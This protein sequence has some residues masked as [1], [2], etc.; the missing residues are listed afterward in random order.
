MS[1]AQ[2][3]RKRTSPFF[4]GIY[5]SQG[6][7][8]TGW[9]GWHTH[10]CDQSLNIGWCCE[11]PGKA[12]LPKKGQLFTLTSNICYGNFFEQSTY[13]LCSEFLIPVSETL[14]EWIFEYMYPA[15]RNYCKLSRGEQW[16]SVQKSSSLTETCKAASYVAI[17]A[18]GIMPGSSQHYL[19]LSFRNIWHTF[20]CWELIALFSNLELSLLW[21]FPITV[22][23]L[24]SQQALPKPE[25]FWRGVRVGSRRII[26][27]TVNKRKFSL[28]QKLQSNCILSLITHVW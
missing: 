19:S 22:I 11:S 7:S 27:S 10:W 6:R 21:Y 20:S 12:A 23:L 8:L 18:L 24:S 5:D 26:R 16:N 9:W 1:M 28:N 2:P 13:H 4:F 25:L 15:L 17:P 3:Q 14:G